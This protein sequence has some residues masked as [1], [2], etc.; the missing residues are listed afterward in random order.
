[1]DLPDLLA[2]PIMLHMLNRRF[3]FIDINRLEQ[4][5]LDTQCDAFPNIFELL[6]TAQNDELR[7]GITYFDFPDQLK[8]CHPGHHNVR[9][10]EIDG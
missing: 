4:I 1:M 7:E 6:I 10:N 2:L 3:Q 9:D 5:V 8:S